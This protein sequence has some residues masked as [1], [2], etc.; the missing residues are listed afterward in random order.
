NEPATAAGATVQLE[1]SHCLI[2]VCWL[3]TVAS[4]TTTQNVVPTHAAS[5]RSL[6]VAPAGAGVRT[7]VQAVPFHCS[8]KP[9]VVGAPGGS[10]V[11]TAKHRVELA[12]ATPCSG[13]AEARIGLVCTFHA[14]PFHR[15]VKTR[16]FVWPEPNAP[17]P[18]AQHAVGVG[19]LTARSALRRAPV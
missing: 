8:T 2:S 19:Q 7:S 9:R 11:P 5:L 18:T 16:S 13:L 10:R 1:P 4:P 3:P 14:E 15:S 6:P 17:P 12:H